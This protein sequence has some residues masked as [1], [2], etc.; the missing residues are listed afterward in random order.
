MKLLLGLLL[1]SIFIGCSKRDVA[2]GSTV[3]TDN[4]VSVRIFLSDGKP[5]ASALARVRPSWAVADTATMEF[6]P[7]YTLDYLADSNGWVHLENLPKGNYSI[8][9]LRNGMGSFSHFERRDTLSSES[10][11]AIQLKPLGSIQGQ[12]NLPEG[13]IY[14]YVQ[15][16]GLDR[17][18]KTDS[19]GKFVLD[20]LPPAPLHLRAIASEQ[21]SIISDD[22]I[23][24]RS[25]Y[26]M[27][28]GTIAD[29]SIYSEDPLTWR[30]SKTIPTSRLFS[31][32]MMP[33]STPSVGFLRL[34]ST[35]FD[36]SEAMPDGRDIRLFDEDGNRLIYQRANWDSE[37]KTALLRV[38]I[39]DLSPMTL[40]QLQWGCTGAVEPGF[41]GLWEGISD[42]VKQELYTVDIDDFETVS[43][44]SNLPAPITT[45]SWFLLPQDTNVY[46][47]P[48][49][50]SAISGIESAGLGRSGNAFHYRAVGLTTRWGLLGLKIDTVPRNLAHIDS[51]VFWI[52]GTGRYQFAL[53]NL[54]NGVAKA[55]YEGTIDSL[56]TRKC[57][58]PQDFIDGDN[59]GG[60][61]GWDEVKDSITNLSFFVFG[62][63]EIWIDD[64]RIYGINRDD[65]K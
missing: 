9:V 56:W 1:I 17:I 7:H 59:V 40:I 5:A 49:S 64:I 23:Q 43:L 53:E 27:D 2:G 22:I 28:V 63:S 14:A 37:R 26:A 47:V 6:S 45:Q 25:A 24:V 61:A 50:D 8:E 16:Y 48:S 15:V 54:N 21:A 20:S 33:I 57:V 31:D 62:N 13:S 55:I 65:L 4:A 29:A 3:E 58:R 34:D 60:N 36:F 46:T 11:S 41:E 10:L 12:V 44:E 38:R 30:Y 35:N 18:V 42:S 32:W 51:L 39:L 19:L 52:R